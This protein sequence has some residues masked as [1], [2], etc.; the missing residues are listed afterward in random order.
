VIAL[1]LERENAIKGWRDLQGPTNSIKAVEEAPN[2]LRARFGTDGTQNATHGS[3][4]LSN[5]ARELE[6]WFPDGYVDF[7]QWPPLS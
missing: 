5:A 3:D 1:A 4:S 2:S 6:F 7:P